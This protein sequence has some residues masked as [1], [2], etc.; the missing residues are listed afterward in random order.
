MTDD[1]MGYCVNQT[2]FYHFTS[3]QNA[4]FF[5]FFLLSALVMTDPSLNKPANITFFTHPSQKSIFLMVLLQ[6]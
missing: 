6:K 4:R 2:G 5:I 3:H 1:E